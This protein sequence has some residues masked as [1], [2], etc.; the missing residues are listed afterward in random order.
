MN[1]I[2]KIA[3]VNLNSTTTFI[4]Q[5]ML[6]D[7][8]WN[9]DIDLLF[10]QEL[11]YQNF[12]FI[13]S[14]FSIV[15]LSQRGMGTGILL[16]KSFE[17]N[18]VILDPN[19]RISS[20]VINNINFI[21]IYAHSGTNKK[22]ERD[23]L[24]L[25]NLTVHLSKSGVEYS[26]L[27]GDFNCILNSS[28]ATGSSNNF[29]SGLKRLVDAFQWKDIMIEKR[30][31]EFTFFRSGASSRLD[32]FYGPAEFVSKVLSAETI[33]VP[34]SDHC[35]VVLKIKINSEF[36]TPKGKGYWKINTTILAKDLIAEKFQLEYQNIRS[37][38]IYTTDKN[39]WWNTIA[40]SKI[41][42]FYKHESWASNEQ[43][44]NEKSY[45]HSILNNLHRRR[46]QGEDVLKDVFI[47][48]S[49]LIEIEN[50]RL[51]HYA[52][53]FNS[54]SI[55]QGE[56]L[57]VFQIS[58]QLQKNNKSNNLKLR[59]GNV[60]TGDVSKLKSII[61][62]YF[63]NQFQFTADYI[64]DINNPVEDPINKITQHLS[65]EQQR[66]ITKPITV[67]EMY[68]TLKLCAKKKSPGP[69]GLNYEFYLKHFDLIKNDLVLLFNDY[70]SGIK[71]P[72]RE[73]SAGVITLIHKNGDKHDLNQYRPISMLNCD[74]KL[75]T[76]ILA[77]RIQLYLEDLLGPEQSACKTNRACTDNLKD[78]RR[79]L[80]RAKDTVKFKGALVSVDLQK[81]FDKVNHNYLWKVLRKFGF[82]DSLIDCI[83]N[84]YAN[85][86]SKVLFNGFL[87]EDIRI[88]SSVRQ[89]CPLSMI[90]FI[91]Y[92]EPLLREI[93]DGIAGVLI[94]D[95]FI[96]TIAYADDINVFIRNDYEFDLLLQIFNSFESFAQIKL[97]FN[98]SVFLRL[99]RAILGPQR[100]TEVQS[101]KIL[102]I[103][104]FTNIT[105]TIN[106]NYD[107][108]L[109]N[110]KNTLSIHCTRKLNLFERSWLLNAFILSK[111]WYVAQIFPPFKKHINSINSAVGKFLWNGF[112]FKTDRNQL[113]LD[114]N[115]GG[116][117]LVNPEWKMKALFIRNII[118]ETGSNSEE[119]LLSYRK[120]FQLPSFFRNWVANSREIKINPHLD[121]TY[122]IYRFF[123]S[124]TQ[125]VPKVKIDA[126]H[127]EWSIVWKNL[128]TNF[129]SSN[130]KAKLFAYINN[131]IPNKEKLVAYNIGRVTD[132]FC[133]FCNNADSN[134]HRVSECP[135][136]RIISNWTKS[137]ISRSCKLEME[138]LEDILTYEI[139]ENKKSDNAAL[140]L[141]VR[142][143]SFNLKCYPQPSLFVF[144]K[145]LREMRWN[146]REIFGRVFGTSLNIC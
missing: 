13:P 24:F 20:I 64:V 69:D 143:M 127:V 25:N 30:K 99:N 133:D 21:N 145:E 82:P 28:D 1:F 5:N 58:S 130:D 55:V 45:F 141:S 57:N 78:I 96:K 60:I 135:Q 76:K 37:R 81:A 66:D 62:T 71:K 29:S 10:V 14:H 44:F 7:F 115:M 140:F 101:I 35:A 83:K 31:S 34:F 94:Y 11:C 53:K 43:I 102:G 42:Q 56:I 111:F 98:K 125:I 54:F 87:T 74:Y 132:S 67:D 90:L 108:I 142:A 89:G 146:N 70:L 103:E 91:L 105:E 88:L 39:S 65:H 50:D 15:N 93:D 36:F 116:I 138:H 75:F 131:I 92:I 27:G 137:V 8:V 121:S 95:K 41:K 77:T 113:Y 107:R 6:R 40:K 33:P 22:K 134:G 80:L 17:F 128:S 104:F 38:L 117:G 120:L 100:I 123:L 26:V 118:K 2:L 109:S 16:R 136:A 47:V 52:N 61:H 63:S 122:N 3:T 85:A 18:N 106:K 110:V 4:N 119:Y 73:F 32:R 126:P 97:N 49:R 144:K 124:E 139:D 79:I 72:P 84:L 9:H 23:E 114:N 59:D 51:K 129:I 48:K 68:Q 112:I 12:S 86:T 19:G 46:C